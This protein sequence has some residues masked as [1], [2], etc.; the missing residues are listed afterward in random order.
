METETYSVHYYTQM[1]FL[2]IINEKKQ[3]RFDEIIFGWM[4][5]SFSVPMPMDFSTISFNRQ[6]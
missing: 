1:K 4:D 2:K 5:E 6:Q 3:V